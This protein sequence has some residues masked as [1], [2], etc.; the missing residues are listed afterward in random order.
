[1]HKAKLDE[2]EFL[3]IFG[4][5]LAEI[6]NWIKEGKITDVKTIISFYWMQERLLDSCE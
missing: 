5:S 2:G 6:H 3:D 1:M 4:A